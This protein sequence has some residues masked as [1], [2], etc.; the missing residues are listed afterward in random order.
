M[1]TSSRLFRAVAPPAAIIASVLMIH[2]WRLLDARVEAQSA[3]S[4]SSPEC[5]PDRGAVA[6]YAGGV[7]ASPESDKR[8]LIP[9]ITNPGWR[10]NELG[11]VETKVGTVVLQPAFGPQGTP[12]GGLRSTD[13]GITW[14]FFEA[15][16]PNP[17]RRLSLDQDLMIDRQTDRLFWLAP[18]Y[19]QPESLAQTSRSDFSD[20]DGKTWTKAS[21]PIGMPD[22]ATGQPTRDHGF[23][24]VGPPPARLR[25][26]LTDYPN[27]V[28]ACG[29]HAPQL[30]ARSLD[31]GRTFSTPVGLPFP[32]ECDGPFPPLLPEV[33]FNTNF[34]LR[35]VADS[36]GTVYVPH[37]PCNRPYV[38]ISRDGGTTWTNS[39]VADTIVLGYGMI[40]VAIDP[41]DNLYA[42][43]AELESR[44]LFFS[45]SRDNG[46]HWSTPMAIAAPGVN[47]TALPMIVV[48]E[49][50]HAVVAY[51]GS[52]NSPGAP[53]PPKCQGLPNSC[54]A[55]ENQ[56]WNMYVTA[57]YNALDQPAVFWSTTLND[58]KDPVLYGCTPS[59]EGVV[60]FKGVFGPGGARGPCQG[61]LDYFGL[62]MTNDELTWVA[63][64]QGCPG[65][66]PVPGNPNCPSS[67]T[68]DNNDRLWT[69]VGRLVAN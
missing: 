21:G 54:P 57:T 20:D 3:A 52:T 18:G 41:E 40:S 10:T 14:S 55:Y 23:M 67:L 12:V 47:E 42:T 2:H 16:D 66:L 1:T 49:R 50:G 9:C 65:G 29:A 26:Q 35:G 56:T 5:A 48:G 64:A 45:I 39:R 32:R 8:T 4:S 62:F 61:T 13:Q 46:A 31:G 15:T 68:G 38:A 17:P 6:H 51:Y 69:L 27:V 36:T 58:P 11:I 63:F 22:L 53:F 43:W 44:M 34:G 25:S 28:Y 7:Q 33:I 59:L 19:V 60:R 37:A 24:F 30:C